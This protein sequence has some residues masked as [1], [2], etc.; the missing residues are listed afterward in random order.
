MFQ[1]YY[2][3]RADALAET[4][5]RLLVESG[6]DNPLQP[7]TV[8]VPQLGLEKWLTRAL[9]ERHGIAANIEFIAPAKFAWRLLRAWQQ[10]LAGRSPFDRDV[11]VWRLY[12]LL[13]RMATEDRF[14]QQL[15]HGQ[16]PQLRRLQVAGQFAH[17]FERYQAYRVQ[18]LER[19]ARGED[20]DELQARLWR[21][22]VEASDEAPRSRLMSDFIRMFGADGAPRPQS[23]PA[24]VFAYGCVNVSPLVLDM[25]MVLARHADLH[26]LVPTPCREYWGDLPSRGNLVDF[27]TS[28]EGSFLQQAP[29]RLLVSLGGVGR[30]FVGRVFAHD[31]VQQ[32]DADGEAPEPPRQTLL[33]RVQADIITLAQPDADLQR[34][35]PDPADH[36]IAVQRCH[37]PLREVQV[38]HDHL[39]AMLAADDALDPRDIVVMVPDLD[40]YAASVEAVFGAIDERDRRYLPWTVADRPAAGAHPVTALFTQLLSLP[41][42]RLSLDLV[43]EVLEV[44][45]VQ[46][47]AGL[48][49]A[50]LHSLQS[51][52]HEAGIRWGEDGADRVAQGLPDFDD[53]SWSF[54]RRRLLL[55]YMLGDDE[56][57]ALLEG[58]AP[59]SDIEGDMAHA[60]GE[61]LR[62]ERQLHQLRQA[63]LAPRTARQ[64]QDLFNS[65]LARLLEVAD[66][67]RE[68]ARALAD[69]RRALTALVDDSEQAALEST[70]DWTCLR[71]TLLGMLEDSRPGQRF[72]DGG[73][74]VCSMVPM[75]D[76]PF[77][78]VC[79]LGLDA[80]AFPRRDEAD[81]LS[82]IRHDT[83][84]PGDRSVREDDRYLF[85]QTIMAARRNLYLSYTGIDLQSGRDREPSV[86]LTEF[87][88]HVCQGYFKKPDE[89]RKW[90]VTQQPMHPFSPRLFHQTDS[91]N[92]P[93]PIFTYRHEWQDAAR[94]RG[95]NA[96]PG[97][98]VDIDWPA[99]DPGTR[100]DLAWMK[101]FFA[102]PQ[103]AFL[104]QAG[105]AINDIDDEVGREPLVL[106]ALHESRMQRQLLGNLLSRANSGDEQNM[107]HLRAHA[108]LPP[109][110]VGEQAYADAH[111]QVA[112]QA[113][114][115]RN[116]AGSDSPCGERRRFALDLGDA[117]ILHGAIEG[118]YE[119]GFAGWVGRTGSARR[120]SHWW[121][122]ALV[123][124]AAID[125]SGE[126]CAFGI[127][128]D[129]DKLQLPIVA[130]MPSREEAREHLRKL[131]ILMREGMRM[132]FWLPPK[133]GWA[134][135]QVLAAAPRKNESADD[136]LQRAFK[137]AHKKWD[138]G[139]WS[140]SRDPWV[141]MVLRGREPFADPG[142][143]TAEA[144]LD[145][146]QRIYVPL[147]SALLAGGAH[148]NA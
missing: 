59:Q 8:L 36:S 139:S 90:L 129:K 143:E 46:Q 146:A 78:T 106:D 34:E 109:L 24:Q 51:M 72:M 147:W 114:S 81:A 91:G 37:S 40:R 66:D 117:G 77:K 65:H 110:A 96:V 116:W 35:E 64:W 26:F 23:L 20:G 103:R 134:L 61:L 52:A 44:P 99:P 119:S 82:F 101:R 98:F 100:I 80:D 30:E 29:N 28:L 138:E 71:E 39:L 9:A 49:G 137:A 16:Q 97:L 50:D 14:L 69:V 123:Y 128:K 125:E 142:S 93:Q 111:A 140:D 133:S 47:A 41:A 2:D 95:G 141:A 92:G 84:Q 79:V 121:L 3:T 118:V 108:L 58:I 87:V 22:L 122:D 38:L 31:S 18:L 83:W 1:L 107:R 55:G 54:G 135:A 57:E 89:A 19:W 74:S 88:E 104:Q 33:Q 136:V 21:A 48:D 105:L 127:S 27:M 45:A 124:R 7:R 145:L 131:A 102:A 73:V 5:A 144:C 25:L 75:R 130:R 42:V 10:Q 120:W 43:L 32:H 113:L 62:L 115:W 13:P 6:S 12:E 4:L 56:N 85:L 67:D 60:F 112:P 15:L 132:P 53:F 76:V 126:C 63:M 94:Q 11:L 68:G 86:L 70:L 17:L 148:G